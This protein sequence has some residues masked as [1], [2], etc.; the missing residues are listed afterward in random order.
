MASPYERYRSAIRSA[1]QACKQACDVAEAAWQASDHSR[2]AW[3]ERA[4]AVD[5]A[6]TA[7]TARYAAAWQAYE[8]YDRQGPS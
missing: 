8:N 3:R 7:R 4:G 1:D 5:S 6:V 2:A